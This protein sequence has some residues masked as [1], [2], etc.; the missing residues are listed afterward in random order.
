MDQTKNGFTADF[1]VTTMGFSDRTIWWDFEKGQI[2]HYE[3]NFRIVIET[4]TGN[5]YQFSGKTKVE[6]TEFKRTATEEAVQAVLEKIDG[7]GLQD[8]SVTKTDRGLTISLENIQFE[9]NSARLE[10]SEKTKIKKIGEI[11]SSYPDNDLLVSGHTA[12]FGS[13][14][15]CQILSEQRAEAVADFLTNLGIR[16]KKHVFTQGFGSKV[17]VASN[18]DKAGMAKNRRVEITILDR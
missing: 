13:E 15:S 18:S 9:A 12:R 10:K 1:P 5:E 2:D 4:L 11:L 17:P 8:I 14:E 16:E 3:E 7:M 6:Y